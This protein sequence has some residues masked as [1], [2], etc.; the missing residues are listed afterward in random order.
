MLDFLKQGIFPPYTVKSTIY[1]TEKPDIQEVVSYHPE[2]GFLTFSLFKNKWVNWNG[3]Y[4][5]TL[6]Q[7]EE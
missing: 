1:D 4:K 7:G 5:V 3:D 2:T 6:L